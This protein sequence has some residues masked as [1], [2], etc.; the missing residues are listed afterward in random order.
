MV[1]VLKM[2]YYFKYFILTISLFVKVYITMMW[3]YILK[4]NKVRSTET[5]LLDSSK[6]HWLEK[7]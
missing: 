4:K 6:A 1:R 5:G 2:Y 7:F 3:K